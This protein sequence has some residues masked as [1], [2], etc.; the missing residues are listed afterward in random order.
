L[1]I[2]CTLLVVVCCCLLSVPA[3]ADVLSVSAPSEWSFSF[4]TNSASCLTA[5]I[6]CLSVE[7]TGT[8]TLEMVT[9]D[10]SA[11]QR[12][13][14]TS[15]WYEVIGMSGQL[16]G[17]PVSFT[18]QDPSLCSNELTTDTLE[19]FSFAGPEGALGPNAFGFTAGGQSWFVQTP[20]VHP[21]AGS[22]VVAH[23]PYAG[24]DPTFIDWD[25]TP[26]G[27]GDPST[28]SAVLMAFAALSA[29]A[30]RRAGTGRG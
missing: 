14:Q 17:A 22:V 29:M 5:D 9:P 18:A 13:C 24:S 3:R 6:P 2:P 21:F 12:P 4:S 16:N 15:P 8:L 20:A 28:F 19:P 25:V 23:D 11:P 30:Y 1:K 27:A 7:A 26:L 10:L